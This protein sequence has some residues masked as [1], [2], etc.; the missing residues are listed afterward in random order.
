MVNRSG[1]TDPV[2]EDIVHQRGTD[3]T[4]YYSHNGQYYQGYAHYRRGFMRLQAALAGAEKGYEN[5][6]EHIE[7]G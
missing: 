7:G 2:S 3:K 5:Q 6:P 4:C 1:I